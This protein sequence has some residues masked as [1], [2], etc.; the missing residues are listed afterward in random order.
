MVYC[1][2][3]CSVYLNWSQLVA[4][5]DKEMYERSPI[6]HVDDFSCPI[7]IFQG[8]DDKVSNKGPGS[9]DAK[10]HYTRNYLA[11]YYFPKYASAFFLCLFVSF[12][13]WEMPP[14]LLWLDTVF[15][16]F[17][18]FSVGC[19]CTWCGV[20]PCQPLLSC[21]PIYLHTSNLFLYIFSSYIE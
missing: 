9:A 13:I 8:L 6:N 4:G 18:A 20:C 14:H 16:A 5:G 12:L 17:S 7:I 1:F 10:M 11:F 15:S 3:W 2:I 21:V 19:C